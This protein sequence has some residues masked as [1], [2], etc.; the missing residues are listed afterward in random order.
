VRDFARAGAPLAV[1][2]I[3]AAA[4]A[5]IRL[6]RDEPQA[7]LPA[8]VEER[9]YAAQAAL[10]E[11]ETPLDQRLEAAATGSS[12]HS[13]VRGDFDGDG[14]I[15]TALVYGGSGDCVVPGPAQVA[16]VL[17]TGERVE[18]SLRQEEL[19]FGEG[20]CLSGCRAVAAFDLDRDRR[21]ELAL[22]L[23]HGASQS[24]FGLF[25]FVDSRLIRIRELVGD[26]TRTL[27]FGHYGSLCCASDT[28]CRRH[29]GRSYVVDVSSGHDDFYTH[30]TEV[31]YLYEGG[32][33]RRTRKREHWY[34]W[35]GTHHEV[36]GRRCFDE[37][38]A[39][40][41]WRAL[42]RLYYGKPI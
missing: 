17:A 38:P 5:G 41:E 23:G 14:A 3:V 18:R 1:A 31:E 11:W 39:R 8:S 9:S 29:D 22:E 12:C 42:A 2:V 25:R 10:E 20:A 19:R 21:D 40:D 32:V 36:R 28:L 34:R 27:S 33:L 26:R 37:T 16:L 30:A 15:D 24:F 35:Q 7:I 6:A 13:S 4:I